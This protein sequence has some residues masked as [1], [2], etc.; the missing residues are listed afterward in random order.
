MTMT[1]GRA[2]SGA[3]LCTV[4][5]WTLASQVAG[6]TCISMDSKAISEADFLIS[7]QPKW[8]IVALVNKNADL[9]TRNTKIAKILR[10]Y[11]EKHDI[12]VIM[13]SEHNFP[14]ER[15]NQWEKTFAG[16]ATVEVVDT[17]S[18]KFQPP[19]PTPYGY[20]YMCKFFAVDMYDFLKGYD[21]YLRCDHDCYMEKMNYDLLS[22]VEKNDVQYGFA[23]RKLEAHG[24]TKQTL[25]LW[26]EKYN[27]RCNIQPT[28]VMDYS[29]STCF[30]FYNNFHV[31]N[32]HF[33]RRPD[34]QHFLLA[35]NSS[36]FILSHRWGDSTIQAYA[37]R[38]FM[39]PSKIVQL[40][41]MVY[42]HESHHKIISTFG[43]GSESDVPQKLKMWKAQNIEYPFSSFQ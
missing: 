15:I 9:T 43:D 41:N 7:H 4:I 13:F 25:P 10:P 23:L 11:A 1:A 17:S 16:V 31:G 20:K 8:A 38:N 29:F 27:N 35:A 37:V 39:T 30:N 26:T 34:V 12:T 28:A 40:P 32:V 36:G 42:I 22:F 14:A 33:F 19:S 2:A 21:Y 3:L 6:N 5:L 24:P 18:R